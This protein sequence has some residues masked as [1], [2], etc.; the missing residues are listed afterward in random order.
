MRYKL[1]AT[2]LFCFGALYIALPN[3][4]D[5]NLLLNDKIKFGLDLKGGSSLLLKIDFDK[6]VKERLDILMQEVA[7]ELKSKQIKFSDLKNGGKY[8]F[9]TLKDINLDDLKKS[10]QGLNSDLVVS[11]EQHDLYKVQFLSLAKLKQEILSDS[12]N[13]IQRR[14]DESGTREAIVQAQGNDRI[15][16]QVP[17]LENPAQ[18]KS[19]LGRTAK[20][21]FHL[22]SDRSNTM[23]LRDKN[24]NKYPV[25]RRVE[26]T[27]DFLNSASVSLNKFGAPV[28][29]FRFNGAGAKK[30]AKITQDNVG[31]PFAIILDEEVLTVPIIREPILAGQGEISGNFTLEEAQ[32]LAILLRSG[33][34]PAPLNIIEERVVG[35]SL[36]SNAISAGINASIASII[37]I[38]L[39]MIIMYRSFGICAAIAL[40]INLVI[41]LAC[42]TTIGATLTLPGIAGI[43]LTIGMAVDANVL[44][45]ERIKEEYNSTKQFNKSIKRGFNNAMSAIL[46]SN[47]TTLIAALI[48]FYMGL[49]PIRGFA[50]TLSVGILSSMFS[51]IIITKYMISLFVKKID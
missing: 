22:L 24:G 5:S 17:G 10:I 51:A 16:L 32:D 43:V 12:I 23:V 45:F 29:T 15:T 33:A 46:D 4:I 1:I 34:L 6:Y 39:F 30:F 27:G 20:L 41:M 2:I 50:I 49:G 19:L 11:Y 37:I 38:S 8:L 21:T 36:G 9:L 35:P 31:K 3:F 13:S 28:V 44:I 25:K 42:L 40:W 18:L 48:M 7:T 14:V 26:L 47:I